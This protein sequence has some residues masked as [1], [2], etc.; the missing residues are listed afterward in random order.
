MHELSVCT[1][2]LERVGQIASERGARSVSRIELRIG[3]L[4]GIELP[5]LLRAWP[6]AAAGTLAE[7]AELVVGDAEL[8]VRCTCCGRESR[9]LPN[10]LLCGH[11]GDFR[12]RIVSGEDLLLERLELAGV[13]SPRGRE[14]ATTAAG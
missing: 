1:A 9:A 4:S 12:T 3:P 5:L 13:D 6:L 14:R 2:L 10:R 11:C 8:R 7:H